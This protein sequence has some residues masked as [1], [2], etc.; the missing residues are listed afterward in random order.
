MNEDFINAYIEILNK[1]VE[2]LVKS[3]IMLLTRY[4]IAEKTI[5][6]FS[7]E[8]TKLK[9]EIERLSNNL[10]TTEAFYD[11]SPKLNKTENF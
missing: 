4:T 2:E 9:A 8:N 1:R 7:E 3:E 6:A 11:T 10:I 5:G